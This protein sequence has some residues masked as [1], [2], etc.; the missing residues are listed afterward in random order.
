[1]E[2]LNP[3]ENFAYG[4]TPSLA[5]VESLVREIFSLGPQ[6]D[7]SYYELSGR[8]DIRILVVRTLLTYLELDGYLEGGTPFYSTYKFKPLK[9]SQEILAHFDGERREFVAS[10]FRQVRKAKTWMHIDVDAAAHA[11]SAPRDRIVRALDYL[12]EQRWIELEAEGTRNQYRRLKLPTDRP[13]LAA[14]LH[15]RTIDREQRE[16]ARLHQV[17]DL[18]RSPGCQ[19]N[20]LCSHFGENRAG[21]C[22]HCTWCIRGGSAVNLP[23]RPAIP[24]DEN[25]I[26]RAMALREQHP[27]ALADASA[28]TRLLCG[29]TSPGLTRAKLSGNPL[30]GAL[31]DADFPA[32]RQK[33]EQEGPPA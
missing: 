32:V 17:L 16:I 19:V 24:I 3:L 31:A 26:R 8:H 9:S 5:S 1:M 12:G 18:V 20:A 15:R 25:V 28:L 10:I 27:Q 13:A 22:G 21:P 33:L 6:F 14:E 7:V 29:I 30:F 11:L 4:D 2:D 23:D